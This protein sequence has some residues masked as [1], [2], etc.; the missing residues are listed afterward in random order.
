MFEL[1]DLALL[2]SQHLVPPPNIVL[3]WRKL[4]T[5]GSELEKISFGRTLPRKGKMREKIYAIALE[6]SC[7]TS[8]CMREDD[9]RRP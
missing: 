8:I 5:N 9:E 7:K 4:M 3:T 1:P 6:T 2:R